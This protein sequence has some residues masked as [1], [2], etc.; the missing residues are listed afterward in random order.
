MAPPPPTART[1][2]PIPLIYRIYFLYFDPL[3]AL[4]GS[5]LCLF[6]PL[7]MLS[8]TLPRPAYESCFADSD[9]DAA[10]PPLLQMALNN[11]GALYVLFAIQEGVVLRCTRE[12]SVWIAVMVGMCCCDV[13][14]I[15]AVWRIWP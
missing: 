8:G 7:R 9:S 4:A 3:A 15:Y 5:Y 12:R 10:I 1:I 6:S 14:H 11:I 2:S 13:G